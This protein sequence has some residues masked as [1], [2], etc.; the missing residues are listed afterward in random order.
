M[1]EEQNIMLIQVVKIDY[2]AHQ[3]KAIRVIITDETLFCHYN[4]LYCHGVL[5]LKQLDS[6]CYIVE[7]DH[8]NKD[9]FFC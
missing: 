4:N 9:T 3:L 2:A 5:Y 1:Y 7:R 8:W 6:S